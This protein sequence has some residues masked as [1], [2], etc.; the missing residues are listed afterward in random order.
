[1]ARIG[2]F[3]ATKD[4]FFG[5]IQTLQIQVPQV[6]FKPL[7]GDPAKSQPAYRIVAQGAEIGAAWKHTSKRGAEF[8][9]VT[10]DDPSF[11]TPIN[12]RLYPAEDGFDLVWTRA[13]KRREADPETQGPAEPEA[14]DEA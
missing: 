6:E 9:S 11:P 13:A 1:M 10:L 8:L 2:K 5:S 3:K 14:D 12:A 7:E 4:G